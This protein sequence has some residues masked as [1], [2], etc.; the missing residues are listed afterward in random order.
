VANVTGTAAAEVTAR[1]LSFD[2]D[3]TLREALPQDSN[4]NERHD[5]ISIAGYASIAL[6]VLILIALFTV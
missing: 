4:M 6:S 5:W 3:Q 1:V 2:V